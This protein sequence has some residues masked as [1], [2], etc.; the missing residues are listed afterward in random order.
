MPFTTLTSSA[1]T[2]LDATKLTGNLP[3]LNGSAL[4]NID[5][6]KVLQL[7]QDVFTGTTFTSTTGWNDTELSLSIT[8]S[9]SSNKILLL[10]S[11]HAAINDGQGGFRFMRGSTAIGIADS[12]GSRQRGTMW[13]NLLTRGDEVS[14]YHM[15]FLDSPSTTSSTTYK[16]QYYLQRNQLGINT[17][18][19]N[20]TTNSHYVGPI[21]NLIAM[22]IQA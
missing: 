13:G 3:A 20:D 19:G 16:I 11:V 18:Y 10:G 22:E 8:P 9:S 2:T 17:T 1:Y 6:G 15:E 21:S 5:G 7:V 4:T 14:I 12:A